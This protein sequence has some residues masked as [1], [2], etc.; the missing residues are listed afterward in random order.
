MEMSVLRRRC[1]VALVSELTLD[2]VMEGRGRGKFY[3]NREEIGYEEFVCRDA[4]GLRRRF[5][6]CR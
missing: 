2:C 6:A 5:G 4:E 3:T 1:S